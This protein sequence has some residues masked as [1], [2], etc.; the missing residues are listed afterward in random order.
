MTC[1]NFIQVDEKFNCSNHHPSSWKSKSSNNKNQLMSSVALADR[2]GVRD[3]GREED[4]NNSTILSIQ[5][6]MLFHF[7]SVYSTYWVLNVE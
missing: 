7:G 6:P 2:Q 5:L 1:L 3:T 4:N